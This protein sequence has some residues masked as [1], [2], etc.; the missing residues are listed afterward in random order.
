[1]ACAPAARR[2]VDHWLVARRSELVTMGPPDDAYPR[3]P[4]ERLWALP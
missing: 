1:M 4:C 2:F 3:L